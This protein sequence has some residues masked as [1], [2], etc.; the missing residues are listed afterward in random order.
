MQVL[1]MRYCFLEIHANN[2]A[3]QTL[4]H[5]KANMIFLYQIPNDKED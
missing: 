5:I 3:M 1:A 2:S 4:K